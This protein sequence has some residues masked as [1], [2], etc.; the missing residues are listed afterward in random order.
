MKK[1]LFLTLISATLLSTNSGW[2]QTNPVNQ[3]AYCSQ[4]P[5]TLGTKIVIY[6]AGSKFFADV[7]HETTELGRYPVWMSKG[8]Y[9]VFSNDDNTPF[10]P[11][12]WVDF[13]LVIDPSVQNSTAPNGVANI[14]DEKQLKFECQR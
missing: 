5:E 13:D 2:A 7:L 1:L 14:G 8:T 9:V 12:G 3:I 10:K 6:S 11:A 4:L